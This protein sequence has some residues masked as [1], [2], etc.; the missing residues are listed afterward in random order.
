MRAKIKLLLRR[1]SE[2]IASTISSEKLSILQKKYF[3]KQLC[4]YRTNRATGS[5]V[6]V[7]C[8]LYS[9]GT[10]TDI[11]DLLLNQIKGKHYSQVS[12]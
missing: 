1:Q 12:E 6:N 5:S 9:N 8:V 4:P 3:K 10:C 11:V 2:T 7:G